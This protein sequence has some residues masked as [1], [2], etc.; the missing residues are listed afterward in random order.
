MI[1]PKHRR[2][3]V[4]F[5]AGAYAA[6]ILVN[7]LANLIPINGI[8][9]GAVSD[10]YRNL[11]APTG[12]TFSIWGVIYILLGVYVVREVLGLR[13]REG[14]AVDPVRIRI[15][16]FFAVSSVANVLWIFAW[17]FRV[18]WLSLLLMLSILFCLILISYPLRK[19]DAMTKAAFGVYFGWITVATIANATTWL[20]KL[21]LPVD[22]VGATL[23][24][25][26]VL[27]V[28]LAIGGVVLMI[29]KNLGYSLVIAWAYFGIFL[30]HIDPAQFDRGFIAVMNT[31]LF[32]WIL[33]L[34]LSAFVGVRL[35]LAHRANASKAA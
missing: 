20:V 16:A 9:T 28:G 2:F 4:W 17:H 8:T 11:F 33:M 22:T 14:A 18:I 27:L 10:S 29:Q 24:T 12:L 34:A 7:A 25:V 26:A 31:S 23:Q 35:L 5:S 6:M 13:P 15:D 1:Q 19:T 21:G 3:I 30:K 32:G